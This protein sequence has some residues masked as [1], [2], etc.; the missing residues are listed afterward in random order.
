[1]RKITVLL[2]LLSVA[3]CAPKGT[4]PVEP[5]HIQEVKIP[6]A[7]DKPEQR[8]QYAVEHYWDGLFNGDGI[9]DSTLILGVP[10]EE[11]EQRT[12]NYILLLT[13]FSLTEARKEVRRFF[14][15]IEDRHRADTSAGV[16]QAVT[17]VVSRYMYDPNSPMRNEDLYLPFVSGLAESEFT[18][19]NMRPAYRHDVQMCS[20]NQFGQ[21]APDFRF[22]T[23]KG[24]DMHLY[25]IR[26]DY[27]MLFFS[28]PGCHACQSIIEEVMSR[29]YIGK[30]LADRTLAIVNVY[31][32][33]DIDAWKEYA[34]NYP[35]GW[36]SGY[37]YEYLIRQDLLYNVRAI[38]SLYLLDSEKKVIMKDAPTENV[39]AFMDGIEKQNNQ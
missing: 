7:I 21:Q 26:A 13:Q 24:R 33:D 14:R 28:N 10:K 35:E 1:M 31:I 22:R 6:A 32:D 36:Y 15:S 27:T 25:G 37:D 39:L 11:V 8:V 3:A 17:A 30:M 19:E 16:F 34:V 12:S 29:P 5:R 20:L 4:K 9:T 38:P 2:L 23:L 18:P